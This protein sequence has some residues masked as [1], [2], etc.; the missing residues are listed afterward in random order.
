MLGDAA[1]RPAPRP[2][3]LA[4]RR[5]GLAPRASESRLE[6]AERLAVAGVLPQPAGADIPACFV[7]AL[8]LQIAGSQSGQSSSSGCRESLFLLF[9][10]RGRAHRSLAIAF[11]ALFVVILFSGHRRADRIAGVYPSC[12]P[13]APPSGTSGEAADTAGVRVALTGAVLAFGALVVPANVPDP[14]SARRGRS[15]SRR[16]ARSPKSRPRTWVRNSRSIS[17]AGSE[18]GALC[19]RGGG[20]SGNRFRRGAA[21][22]VVLAPHWV[23]ASV[24]EYYGRDR[25]L[26]PVVAPHNAYW[27]WREEAAGRDIVAGRRHPTGACCPRYFARDARSLRYLPSAST[28]RSSAATCPSYVASGP[29]TAPRRAAL[30]VAP[31]QHRGHAA[32]AMMG[33]G[34]NCG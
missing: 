15:T 32:P 25:G 11:L 23:F 18:C 33:T 8:V 2:L 4:R 20:G 14:A 22:A 31:L 9:S 24:I 13:P 30:R 3:A 19:R 6:R 5:P 16:S 7:D 10:R 26:P 1:A 28:A 27:F 34:I 29:V 21:R 17:P 12:W